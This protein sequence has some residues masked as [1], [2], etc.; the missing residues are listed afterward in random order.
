ML[1]L[2]HLC[3][4]PHIS[5]LKQNSPARLPDRISY[6]WVYRMNS[7]SDQKL[8]AGDNVV[9]YHGSNAYD[10]GCERRWVRNCG[11]PGSRSSVHGVY[12]NV[13]VAGLRYMYLFY[14]GTSRRASLD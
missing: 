7:T 8:R 3:L 13:N 1:P 10:E 4:P 12:N 5:R 11:T 2:S 14:Q 9:C 6:P